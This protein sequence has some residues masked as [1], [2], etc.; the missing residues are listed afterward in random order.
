MRLRY[1]GKILRMGKDRIVRIVYEESRE[2]LEREEVERERGENISMTDTWCMYTKKLLQELHLEQV[3]TSQVVPLE[4]EWNTVI[5]DRIHDRE[6]LHW[7]T[8]C[9]LKP[10]LRTYN[11]LKTQL[12]MEPFLRV[13]HR[14]GIPELVKLRGGT[15][16][17][18]IEKGRYTNEPV[19]E[20][21]CV[22][23]ERNEIEDEK[24]FMLK[25]EAYKEAR[26]K[27][28]TDIEKVTGTKKEEY[29]SE[30]EQMNALLGDKYQPDIK[31]KDKNSTKNKTYREIVIHVMK[32][33]TFSM[34]TRRKKEDLKESGMSARA[35][36]AH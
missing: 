35:G 22:F 3:W 19:N 20:R 15:N 24:H 31:D 32:Y 7:R 28:W 36:A 18:R 25:C 6:E 29:T 23:C 11:L 9:L 13:H 26:E 21:L 17:L 34:R 5:R 4:L 12:R 14:G 16:R 8:Q 30:E 1:L 2:R 33:V 10:K 27:L